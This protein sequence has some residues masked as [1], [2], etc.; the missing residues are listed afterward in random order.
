MPPNTFRGCATG[1]EDMPA[2][3]NL[4]TLI[5]AHDQLSNKGPSICLADGYPHQF[6]GMMDLYNVQVNDQETFC[7]PASLVMKDITA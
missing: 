3:G 1:R 6:L 2:Y 5:G 4:E 7:A